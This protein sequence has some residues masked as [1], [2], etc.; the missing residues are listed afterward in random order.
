LYVEGQAR[1]N[2]SLEVEDSVKVQNELAVEG[3]TQITKDLNVGGYIKAGKLVDTMI[4]CGE[5]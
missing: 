1:V 4:D 5:Y 3:D 2:Q